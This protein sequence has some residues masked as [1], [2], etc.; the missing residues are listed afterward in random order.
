MSK[1]CFAV[2]R[3]RKLVA[4]AFAG[5]TF[6]VAI[7][8]QAQIVQ[9]G[10]GLDG[11]G[12]LLPGGGDSKALEQNYAVGGNASAASV[13]Y[14]SGSWVSDVATGQWI[15]PSD[16]NGNPTQPGGITT[17]TR[18]INGA[19]TIA[20]QF[21]SDN[22]GELLVNGVVVAQGLGWPGTDDSDYT[23]WVSFSANLN[24]GANTIEFEVNNLGGPAGL[25]VA[26]TFTPVPEPTTMVAGMLLL[27]PLGMSTLR[28]LRKRQAA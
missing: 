16:A 13:Y 7:G 12:N 4:V 1:M 20:G 24:P 27:L 22:P 15:D 6:L 26:G 9:I 2:R 23:R 17:Y 25:I 3:L 10:T 28:N 19:G 21:A 8:A 18:T 5:A 11:S 14:G